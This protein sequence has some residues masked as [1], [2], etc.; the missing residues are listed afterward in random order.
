MYTLVPL[1]KDIFE[2]VY[3]L[4]KPACQNKIESQRKFS[5]F[6]FLSDLCGD[7]NDNAHESKKR[8]M[9]QDKNK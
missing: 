6:C 3:Y 5:L 9:K 8:N 4:I 2:C 1:N 7:K